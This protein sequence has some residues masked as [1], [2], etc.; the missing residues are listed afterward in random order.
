MA[1]HLAKTSRPGFR[2]MLGNLANPLAVDRLPVLSVDTS[3]LV[4]GVAETNEFNLLSYLEFFDNQ[5][6]AFWAAGTVSE[7]VSGQWCMYST[8]ADGM[9]WTAPQHVVPMAPQGWQYG[10]AGLWI[11]NDE[12]YAL[13]RYSEVGSGADGTDT[14][15]GPSL[16]LFGR[17]WN[18]S[19]WGAE[20]EIL[21]DCTLDEQ[22]ILLSTG[23]WYAT[24]RDKYF[25]TQMILGDIG[26]WTRIIV[27]SPTGILLNEATILPIG[28][29]SVISYEYRNNLAMTPRT[30][31]RSFSLNVG[32][33]ITEPKPTNFPDARSRRCARRL[34][35]GRYVFCS[36]ASVE[37]NRKKLMLSVSDDGF[38]YD[39][40][41]ILRGEPTSPK[42]MWHN[43]SNRAGYQYP[44]LLEKDGY[45][46]AIYSRDKE[47]IQV[48]RV[49]LSAF[50]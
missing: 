40:V 21:S 22:P 30:L 17:R 7:N 24:G 9:T 27:P 25:N 5:F 38:T 29:G 39:R 35:D 1:V 4:V 36:N 11:R 10:A 20:E 26:D 18:G 31:L 43:P 6:I 2:P 48:S 3:T 45:L 28:D 42:F 34:S 15:Y 14:Y 47:D 37:Y 46:Y 13:Y 23:K 49:D 12:L 41:Y 33:T 32:G 44:Q 8:S 19:G 50:G 16:A